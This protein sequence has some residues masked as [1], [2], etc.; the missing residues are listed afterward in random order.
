MD[1]RLSMTIR[2]TARSYLEI[3]FHRK[4]LLLVPVIF[5]T[6]IAWG[7]SY[8]VTPMYKSTAVVE[9]TEKSKEN[10]YI[11]GFSQAT[12]ISGRMSEILQRIKSRAMIE[13]IIK[14]LNLHENTRNEL[15]Y[16][17]LVEQEG[18]ERRE[19]GEPEQAARVAHVRGF[20]RLQRQHRREQ[21]A[22]GVA[23]EGEAVRGEHG[24]EHRQRE[25][26]AQPPRQRP[27]PRQRG[28]RERARGDGERGGARQVGAAELR[29][30]EL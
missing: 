1:N 9:V 4:W 5:G 16:R 30:Q 8:T 6:L 10:P 14:E 13:D 20:R 28:D 7:Y 29:L 26:R 23:G 19:Q 22:A 15:E 17:S 11:R 25:Q 27:P 3:I 24:A 18:G 12:P 21:G 2:S